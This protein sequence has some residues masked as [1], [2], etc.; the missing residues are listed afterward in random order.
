[1]AVWEQSSE[2]SC[3]RKGIHMAC[4]GRWGA[5]TRGGLEEGWMRDEIKDHSS[6]TEHFQ[7][8]ALF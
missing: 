6:A 4:L 7:S 2:V 3:F 5:G 1:M 8:Q